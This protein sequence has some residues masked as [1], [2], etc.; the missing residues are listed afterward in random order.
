MSDG[1]NGARL[2]RLSV[3]THGPE[4]SREMAAPT[5]AKSRTGHSAVSFSRSGNVHAEPDVDFAPAECR[6]KQTKEKQTCSDEHSFYRL[7]S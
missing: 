7:R 1:G 4:I 3:V 2:L 5:S 6:Y